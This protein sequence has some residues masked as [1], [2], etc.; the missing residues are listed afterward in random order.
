MKVEPADPTVAV[1]DLPDQIETRHQLGFHRPEIDLFERDP[2]RCDFCIVPPAIPLDGKSK[3]RERLEQTI[4][5]FSR[6]LRDR[7]LWDRIRYEEQSASANRSG[8][9][10][11]ERLRE[12]IVEECRLLAR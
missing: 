2:A 10:L 9:S 5:V 12:M 8:N 7:R 3:P 6:Q 4:S 1:E 11:C